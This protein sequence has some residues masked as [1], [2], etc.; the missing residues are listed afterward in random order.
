MRLCCKMFNNS[1]ENNL[2]ILLTGVLS[3]FE[4]IF[5][6]S[7]SV[8]VSIVIVKTKTLQKNSSNKLFLNLAL[9]SFLH[10]LCSPVILALKVSLPT[11]DDVCTKLLTVIDAACWSSTYSTLSAISYDRFMVFRYPLEPEKRRHT[12][13]ISIAKIWILTG[14]VVIVMTLISV[15]VSTFETWSQIRIGILTGILLLNFLLSLVYGIRLL[16]YQKQY[17]KVAS[18]TFSNPLTSGDSA[19]LANSGQPLYNATMT[20]MTLGAMTSQMTPTT[21]S[22]LSVC[23]RNPVTSR[24]EGEMKTARRM[25]AIYILFIA[26]TIPYIAIST[27]SLK[28]LPPIQ[29]LETVCMHLWITAIDCVCLL[30]LTLVNPQYRIAYRVQFRKFMKSCG[31]FT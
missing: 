26:P 24:R 30:V 29:N 25:G 13:V 6:C 10:C 8:I 7:F 14:L 1:S 22:H 27:L 20:L 9:N 31:G 3:P 17:N 28:H 21:T 15:I 16:K 5:G 2:H 4:L 11:S 23:V 18:L 19:G 12:T